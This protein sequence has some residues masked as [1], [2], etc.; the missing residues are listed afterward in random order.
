MSEYEI[1]LKIAEYGTDNLVNPVDIADYD[2]RSNMIIEG[3]GYYK[4][5]NYD[6]EELFG[7]SDKIVG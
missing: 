4:G 3:S 2:L 1:L 5:A 7:L 6:F